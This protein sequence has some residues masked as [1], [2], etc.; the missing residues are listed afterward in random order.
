[1]FKNP[2]SFNGRIRRLEFGLSYLIVIGIAIAVIFV[3]N[4]TSTRENS[5]VTGII[6]LLTYIPLA[7]FS[8]AQGVKRCHDIGK[9]GT[10]QAIPFYVIWML[11]VDGE[12]GPNKY[13]ENPK[14]LVYDDEEGKIY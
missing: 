5:S 2:F 1:M 4:A 8:Y 7:M 12:V 6:V 3:L 13:G 9:G 10:W 11:F 14:G